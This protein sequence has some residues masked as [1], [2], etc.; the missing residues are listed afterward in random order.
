MRIPTNRYAIFAVGAVAGLVVGVV[1]TRGHV[2]PAALA[3][4]GGFTQT[5]TLMVPGKNN[6][7]IRMVDKE[8]GAVCYMVERSMFFSCV[9]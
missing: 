4:T 7:V 8:T 6:A 9:K 5:G 2:I 3:E 1:A